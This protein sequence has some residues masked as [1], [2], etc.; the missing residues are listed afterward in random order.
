MIPSPLIELHN[1]FQALTE[2][3]DSGEEAESESSATY[4]WRRLEHEL[5][6]V[7]VDSH[8]FQGAG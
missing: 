5:T 3:D 4:V 2:E 1:R 7:H 8:W 6:P